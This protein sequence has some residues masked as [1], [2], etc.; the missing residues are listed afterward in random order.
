MILFLTATNVNMFILGTAE[1][2][3]TIIAASIP[4]LRHLFRRENFSTGRT[5]GHTA[6]QSF[7]GVSLRSLRRPEGS[8]KMADVDKVGILPQ[9]RQEES[10]PQYGREESREQYGREESRPQYMEEESREKYRQEELRPRYREEESRPTYRQEESRPQY[11]ERMP[12]Q[13]EDEWRSP[14]YRQDGH[15]RQEDWR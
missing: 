13:G 14:H 10:M 1:P 3:M 7:N 11:Q 9:F 8:I 5:G 2:A 6:D 15:Y 4:I 12:R